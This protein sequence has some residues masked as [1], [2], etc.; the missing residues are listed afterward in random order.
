MPDE[1]KIDVGDKDEDAMEVNISPQEDA[2]D[3]L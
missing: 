2:E 1:T 3:G